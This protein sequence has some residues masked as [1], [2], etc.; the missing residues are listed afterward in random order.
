V[1]P[2]TER[3]KLL[4][5]RARRGERGSFTFVVVFWALMT[6]LLGG[7]VVDGALAITERQRAG[8]IAE[9]AA[10]AAADDLDPNQLRDGNYVLQG[11]YCDQAKL[12]G[13]TSGLDSGQV[14][15]D[16]PPGTFQVPGGPAVPLVTVHV[17]ITYSPIL[18]G[19]FF[20]TN[21]TANA[22]ADAHPQ[23]GF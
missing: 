8:D 10:R 3:L 7:L 5:R 1:S 9:Q 17:Q 20:Q 22:T 2:R 13:T 21:F 12:V 23:P 16:A 4:L 19:M 11:G 6:M 15:C 14:N 18:L